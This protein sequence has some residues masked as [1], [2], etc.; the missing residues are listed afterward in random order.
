ML[1]ERRHPAG[2][3]D[4]RLAACIFA[5]LICL[6]G[7]AQR[8][9][10]PTTTISLAVPYEIDTLDPHQRSKLSSFAILQHFY[11]PLIITG[12]DMLIQPCL[13]ESWENPD[14]LTWVFHLRPNVRFHSGKIMTAEDVVYTLNRVLAHPEF[15]RAPYVSNVI[16]VQ[17]IG[18]NSVRIKTSYPTAILLNKL[19]FIPIIPKGT[20]DEFLKEKED[21]TGHYRLK[22]WDQRKNLITVIRDENYWREKPQIQV[23]TF[24]LGQGEEGIR[25]LLAGEC[26]FFQGA[27][28]ATEDAVRN[29]PQFRVEHK[30]SLYIKYLGFNFRTDD[31]CPMPNDGFR[32][33][34]LRQAIDLAIDRAA[35]MSSLKSYA[36][37]ITQ[38]VPP[39]T[40]GFNPDLSSAAYNPQKAK[41]LLRASN[42][43]EDFHPVLLARKFMDQ[44]GGI[45]KEQ[46]RRIGMNVDIRIL[47][48]DQ[49]FTELEKGHYC[50][51]LSRFG[52]PTGDA[53]DVLEAAFHSYDRQLH[54][55]QLNHGR[56]SNASLDQAIVESST[57]QQL[58]RRKKGLQE[59][60]ATL[61]EEKVW[62]PLYGDQDVYIYDSSFS[63]KP[64]ND[65]LID[66]SEI[67]LRQ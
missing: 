30:D 32:S 19:S 60:M 28:R 47:S 57:I 8:P 14:L 2:I 41:E 61:N 3:K 62:I 10:S 59:I 45:I 26:Q 23:A 36:F 33:L 18:Q 1:N 29:H 20:P 63:W 15:E 17:A 51:F 43:Q 21:G 67:S 42:F 49:F 52:S 64:R 34:N 38:V 44:S 40:F 66:I 12:P 58:D 65:S 7:C 35:L 11:E 27:S 37:S 48:D 25:K 5:V 4:R 50:M 22:I 16:E 31:S 39:F 46:L 13:A 55:G 54:Y 56:Y 6:L 9:H 53:S 24:F